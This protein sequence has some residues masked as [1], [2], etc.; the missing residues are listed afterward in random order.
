MKDYSDFLK[1][2]KQASLFDVFVVSFLLLPFI[3]QAWLDVLSKLTVPDTGK[4]WAVLAVVVFYIVGVTAMLLA[5][6][7]TKKREVAKDQ[8]IAYLQSKG[9]TYASFDKF[10]ERIN[11]GYTD[12]FLES[13]P[14]SFPQELRCAKLK[15]GKRGLGRI[16]EE[17]TDEA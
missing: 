7:R 10:R 16:L 14:N 8:V 15:S 5:N 13:L 1:T 4:Y 17:T 6:G 11:T 2:L 9:F 3:V 12:K